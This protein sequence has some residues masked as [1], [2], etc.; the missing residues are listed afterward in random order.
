MSRTALFAGTFD[1]IT[2]GHEDIIRRALPLFDHITVAIGNNI[3]KRT[4]LFDLDTRR[5]WVE[6]TFS[7]CNNVSAD[8]YSTATIDYCIEHGIRYLIRGIRNPNDLVYEQ[9]IALLNKRLA[10]EVE[11]VFLLSSPLHSDVSS[12][13]QRCHRAGACGHPQRLFQ[14]REEESL[15]N[16]D[17]TD[18]TDKLF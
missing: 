17:N 14:H 4:P 18:S 10:P 2:V 13:R 3:G 8:T 6:M 9:E 1:P 7:D 11:T 12:F 15:L 16:T 5:R